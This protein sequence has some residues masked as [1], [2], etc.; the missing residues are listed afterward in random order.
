MSSVLELGYR[1]IIPSLRRRLVEILHHELKLGKIEIA[2]KLGISPSAVSRYLSRERGATLDVS[3]IPPVDSWLRKL[4]E[5]IARG[6]LDAYATEEELLRITLKAAASRLF[7]RYHLRY[8]SVDPVRC[9]ICP[10]LFGYL[11]RGS[12]GDQVITHLR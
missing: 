8:F 5:G 7:C 4:A 2:R 10:K 12:T 9:G 3:K 11:L 6:D 1:Y